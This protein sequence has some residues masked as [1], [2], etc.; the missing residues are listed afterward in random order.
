[1]TGTRFPTLFLSHGS[2]AL[3]L[4][5]VGAQGEHG[6][7]SAR[8]AAL[9]PELPRPQA[10]LVASAHWQTGA[11][12]VGGAVAPCTI[13]DYG[14]FGSEL[15]RIRYPA[16]GA[17]EVATRV[18]ALLAAAGLH[19]AIDAG[20]GLDH[21]VWV[22]LRHVYPAADVP[23]LPLAL[24]PALGVA[25]HHRIGRALAPLR[26]EGVLVLGSGGLTHNLRVAYATRARADAVPDVDPGVAA[27]ADWIA[28]R[29]AAG[30]VASLLDYRRLAPGAARH[31]PTE[32]H[33]LPLFVA[34]GAGG[35]VPA[36]RRI[37]VGT[38]WGALCLDGFRFD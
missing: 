25:H 37:G 27:F 12:V 4:E 34:L 31:H 6:T 3:A 32:E 19:A 21:G 28:D 30:D 14:G 15:H 5:S 20:R 29:L 16:P 18:V 24:Q 11:P 26:D 38:L 10:V 7:L 2:P 33:L 36:V 35:E 1:M 22:P 13:H 17:P 9:A 8:L 23:V